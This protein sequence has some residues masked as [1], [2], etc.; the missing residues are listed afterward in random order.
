VKGYTRVGT[1]HRVDAFWNL[2]DSSLPNPRGTPTTFPN[3]RTMTASRS[4]RQRNSQR[5][6]SLP[7]HGVATD[8]IPKRTTHED[9]RQEMDI[10]REP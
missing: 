8:R 4:V 9:I 1:G 5:P 6:P 3:K 7:E 2:S 10:E